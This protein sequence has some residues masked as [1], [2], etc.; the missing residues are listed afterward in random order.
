MSQPR[1]RRFGLF[2]REVLAIQWHRG[3]MAASLR[4]G[5]LQHPAMATPSIV[6]LGL[7]EVG[8]LSH[9]APTV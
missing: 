5:I 2:G 4:H 9:V 6:S 8:H 7:P 1:V 3:F